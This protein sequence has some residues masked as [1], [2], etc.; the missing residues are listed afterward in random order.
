MSP[1]SDEG[2]QE[3]DKQFRR[4]FELGLIGMAITSPTK[5]CIAV[6]DEICKILGYERA[7]LLTKT[8][9]EMTHPDDLPADMEKFNRAI[10]GE[11]DSY[12]IDKHG[13]ARTVRLSTPQSPSAAC[14]TRKA[15]SNTSWLC[16]RTSQS[17]SGPRR[18]SGTARRASERGRKYAIARLD[19]H[20]RTLCDY[21]N[22]QFARY[23]GV[24]EELFLAH[25]GSI[26]FIRTTTRG[27]FRLASQHECRN[28]SRFRIADAAF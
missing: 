26:S 14:A 2:A 18:R 24:P 5:R 25:G 7:E 13:F 8:W 4:F 9:A 3:A 20:D 15:P 11:T 17:A 1:T 19:V 10:S 22:P 27:W 12:S 28:P 16:C 23:T 21:V 6:N